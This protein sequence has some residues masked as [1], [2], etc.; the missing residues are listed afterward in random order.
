MIYSP[1][2]IIPMPTHHLLLHTHPPFWI[3][4]PWGRVC[5]GQLLLGVG[6][7]S[8]V[9][10]VQGLISLKKKKMTSPFPG[11]FQIPIELH[12]V[13][14][15][16]TQLPSS[17]L[18]FCLGWAYTGLINAIVIAVCSYLQLPCFSWQTWFPLFYQQ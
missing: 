3:F 13:M 6:T 9:V 7:D 5:V 1:H 15:F 11:S 8:S 4:F 18:G 2:L 12:L 16:S 10:E 17:M 14:L